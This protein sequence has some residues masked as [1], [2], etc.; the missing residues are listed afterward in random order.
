M[1]RPTLP[2]VLATVVA[3][4]VA[5]VAVASGAGSV[6]ARDDFLRTLN[7]GWGTADVGGAWA[8]AGTPANFSVAGGVGSIAL[9][10]A[11]AN[12]AASLALSLQDVSLA[13]RFRVSK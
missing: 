6:G 12:R 3:L 5:L 13:A 9:P 7:G 2:L 8:L 10:I 1:R 4:M 11:G